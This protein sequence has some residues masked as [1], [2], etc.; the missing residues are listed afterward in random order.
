MEQLLTLYITAHSVLSDLQTP[1]GRQKAVV[2]LQS[3]GFGR[4]VLES[5]RSGEVVEE[6]ALA[7]ARDFFRSE[8]IQTLGGLM[9]V[10]GGDFGKRVEGIELRAPFFCYSDEA[11]VSALE[12]EIRKLSRLFDQVVIDD[13]FLTS[14]RCQACEKGRAGRDWASFRRDL[15]CRVAQRWVRASHAE[16]PKVRLTVKFPQYYDRYCRFGYD[17]ERFPDIFDAVWVGAETRDPN[18]LAYGYV[19]PY[20]GY[21]NG[22]WMRACAGPKFE[23]AWFDYID[24]DDQL[25]YDQAVTTFLAAPEQIVVFCYG[26]G[27]FG[28]GKMERVRRAL[29]ELHRLR[30]AAQ[31]PWGVHVI[32]SP[33]SDGNGDLFIMDDLGMMGIPCVPST[34][35]ESTMRSV[36]IPAQGLADPGCATTLAE[37]IASGGAAIVTLNALERLTGSP[38]TMDLFG[39]QPNGVARDGALVE[40][41]EV[42]GQTYP[43]QR[44]FHVAGNL[45]PSHA[46]VLASAGFHGAERGWI[47]VPLITVK[48]HAGG[49]RGVVWNIGTF[50]NDDFVI[51]EMLNVPVPTEWLTLPKEVVDEFRRTAT[52]PLGFT[53]K[54]IPKVA[55]FLFVQ[56]VV[57]VN[58]SPQLAHVETTGLRIVS[59]SLRSDSPDTVCSGGKL[60][61]P[62]HSYA[63]VQLQH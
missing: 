5:Y 57:F 21:V 7:D 22:R 39:Y 2:L 51:N 24:C 29:P 40:S 49:G 54:A 42:N 9:P 62:P 19:Q 25:F 45:A 3:N 18:T 37:I 43:A 11:T 36:I 33:N 60:T 44:P 1:E 14:C 63:L 13:A 20:Q 8:G 15:L 28:G 12:S 48:R 58:Y 23:A 59:D 26:E 56:H 6:S 30:E 50:K 17:A 34:R 31:S 46:E 32:D 38:E 47:S 35:L 55:L 52:E 61:L 4:V 53:V 16:N 41:F 10:Q 27:L